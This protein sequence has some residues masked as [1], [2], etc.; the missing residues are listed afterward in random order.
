MSFKYY[1]YQFIWTILDYVYPPECCG[2]GKK[3]FR[4]CPECSGKIIVNKPIISTLSQP[5]NDLKE[6]NSNEIIIASTTTYEGTIRHSIHK[7]KYQKDIA[8]AEKL[9]RLMITTLGQLSWKI[10]LIVPVPLNS[11][12]YNIRGYNQSALLAFPIALSQNIKYAPKAIKRVKNTQSQIMLDSKN[13]FAN[14]KDAFQADKN[15][16]QRKSILLIDDVATTGA[17]LLSCKKS[18]LDS[19]AKDVF[20]FTLAKTIII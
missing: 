13:R 3:G 20:G 14:M 8:L 6:N 11:K 4:L 15:I 9:S 12:K 16:V 2:C 1:L 10:D 19:G 18:L 7:L 17:T 5:V